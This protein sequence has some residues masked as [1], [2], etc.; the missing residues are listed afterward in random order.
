M[1]STAFAAPAVSPNVAAELERRQSLADA[2]AAASI[3][4]DI[5]DVAQEIWNFIQSIDNAQHAAE[6]NF[7]Q[8][9]VE[10]LRTNHPAKNCIVYHDQDSQTNFVN[11]VHQHYELNLPDGPQTQGY[12][13]YV[14]DSGTFTLV[15][16]GGYINW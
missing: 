11:G 15:G 9:L 7:T 3:A 1:L 16:D 2:N 12:E 8:Q 5:I 4:K 14:F 6:S 13:I 10:R